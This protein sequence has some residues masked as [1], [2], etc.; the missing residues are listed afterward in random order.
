MGSKRVH[1]SHL[2]FANDT[3]QF[4]KN[5][6]SMLKVLFYTIKAFEWL[7]GL[8]INWEKSSIIRL[9]I[10]APKVTHFA[11]LLDC[12]VEA[13]PILYFGLPLGGNPSWLFGSRFWKNSQRNW[14]DGV[15]SRYQRRK[16]DSLRY[17]FQQPST[18]L[19]V[20]VPSTGDSTKENR[21]SL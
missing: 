7:S 18:L 5:E 9:N 17:S 19:H 15:V 20:F 6:D 3:L 4:C 8:K 1:I 14:R 12:R 13:L 10:D 21:K 16:N 11:A 2:Q